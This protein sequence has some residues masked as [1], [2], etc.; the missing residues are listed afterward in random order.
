MEVAIECD[1]Q[2]IAA[3]MMR[4]RGWNQRRKRL[5]G[6]RKH[7][8]TAS[9]DHLEGLEMLDYSSSESEGD[10]TINLGALYRHHH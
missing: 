9:P 8:R 4:K 3:K 6:V 2:S 1:H 5:K 10:E 7:R